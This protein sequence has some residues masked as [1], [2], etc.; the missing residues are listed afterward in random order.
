MP[1][2]ISQC[3]EPGLIA[4]P[5]NIAVAPPPQP[6]D[7]H[8]VGKVTVKAVVFD[9]SRAKI[10]LLSSPSTLYDLPGGRL[11]EGE[12]LE[13]TLERE[14]KEEL[15]LAPNDYWKPYLLNDEQC[16]HVS[17]GQQQLSVTYVVHLKN[18]PDFVLEEGVSDRWVGEHQHL[19]WA[20]GVDVYRNVYNSIV[21]FW[22]M[23][24]NQ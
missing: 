12:T 3:G 5:L 21:A 14:L 7:R 22:R 23:W 16:L 18:R 24:R 9:Q 4:K 2:K 20:P 17:S 10:L 15:G 6:E 11:N 1:T 13:Q 19:C 8:F